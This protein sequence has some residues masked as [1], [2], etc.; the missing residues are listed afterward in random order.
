MNQW[1][2]KRL[3]C[4]ILVIFG[5]AF[6]ATNLLAQDSAAVPQ[7]TTEERLP[8]VGLAEGITQMTGVAI[9]PLVGVSAVG[10]WKYFKTDAENRH[11]LP[12]FCHPVFWGIG[13]GVVALCFFKDSIGAGAPKF[14]KKPLDFI[15]LFE[16]KFSAVVASTA[17]V[18]FVAKQI[19]ENFSA[20]EVASGIGED[21]ALLA[22]AP[23]NLLWILL[24]LSIL[25]FFTVWVVSHAINVLVMLSPFGLLDSFLKLSRT[26]LLSFLA[27]LYALNPVVA[28]VL[29]LIIVVVAAFL[30]PS[31]FRLGVF[32][33]VMAGDY[34]ISLFKKRTF[35]SGDRVRG[36]LVR[37]ASANLKARSFCELKRGENG[38]VHFESRRA[39]FGPKRTLVLP[40]DEPPVLAKGL[41]FPS[42]NVAD[43]ESGK[44]RQFIFLMP[45][46]RHHLE[47][48]GRE[49]AIV[50]IRET[51]IVRGAKAMWGWLGDTV[52]AGRN[53]VIEMKPN[54]GPIALDGGD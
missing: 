2:K 15:E 32:G 9:S 8:G 20:P 13:L 23:I 51:P 5:I 41:I 38:E 3:Q 35:E 31:A 22:M 40:N 29:S 10:I 45:R 47:S 1:R 36:F 44:D 52:R 43:S 18:P 19:A 14:I 50:E 53:K 21:G 6:L 39:F 4:G 49:L 27:L 28:A 17:F 30:A 34:L 7:I 37:Q 11:L 46:H 48:V 12:W 54:R 33:T 25:G 16:D 24:P 42:L 26:A